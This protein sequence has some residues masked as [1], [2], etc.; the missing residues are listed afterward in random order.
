VQVTTD[1]IVPVLALHYGRRT[2]TVVHAFVAGVGITYAPIDSPDT[3]LG[4]ADLR[5]F[6]LDERT[7]HRLAFGNLNAMI[8]TARLHGSPPALMASFHGIESSL[9][10]ADV[11]WDELAPDLPGTPVVAVPARDV[12]VITG[13]ESP[14]GLDKAH[15]CVGRVLFAG[16]HNSLLP[17]LLERRGNRWY[18]FDESPQAVD[19]PAG[20]WDDER[21]STPED[22]TIAPRRYA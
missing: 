15:R 5:Q 14:P 22:R 21:W 11:F 12:L 10:L 1:D 9:L 8:D 17:D 2:S 16:P 4:W 13:S 19:E 18:V 20:S 6:G 3:P 7:L